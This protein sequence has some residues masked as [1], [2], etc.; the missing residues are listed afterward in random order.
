M[1]NKLFTKR[2]EICL[3]PAQFEQLRRIAKNCD[4]TVNE[5]VRE[6]LRDFINN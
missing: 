3:T 1:R 5:L 6:V 2:L 4:Q